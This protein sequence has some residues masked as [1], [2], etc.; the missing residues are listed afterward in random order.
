MSTNVQ[1]PNSSFQLKV[2]E[3]IGFADAALTKAAA[4]AARQEQQ[5]AKMAALAPKL[6]EACVAGERIEDTPAQRQKL[7][8]LVKDPVQLLELAIKIAA[9]RNT[10]EQSLGRTVDPGHMKTGSATPAY[11][12]LNDPRVGMP[13]SALR[14]SD[15][16]LYQ[17]LGLPLP[18]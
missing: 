7:A 14:Q 9:H 2:I 10:A 5:Q 6:V 12:S 18:T 13:T 1:A 11:D 16:V 8:T 4:M 17:R 3:L 15:I